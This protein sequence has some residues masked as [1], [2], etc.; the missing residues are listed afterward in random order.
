M[1]RPPGHPPRPCARPDGA[2]SGAPPPV[3]LLAVIGREPR[4]APAPG[5]RAVCPP[6]ASSSRPAVRPPPHAPPSAKPPVPQAPDS[7]T[8][9][10]PKRLSSLAR[11]GGPRN[12][13]GSEGA[14][15]RAAAR[16]PP[17]WRDA[18]LAPS[19]DSRGDDRNVTRAPSPCSLPP[20]PLLRPCRSR[21][22]YTYDS[23][24]CSVSINLQTKLTHVFTAG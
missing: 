17:P 22:S 19:C 7:T 11:A 3:L 12:P 16:P 6:S 23:R 21:S 10:T 2:E 15:G 13:D 20:L 24:A 14:L 4:T 9:V 1:A 8:N 18:E 5:G